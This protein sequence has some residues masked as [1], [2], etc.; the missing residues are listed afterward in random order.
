MTDTKEAFEAAAH[1]DV[2]ARYNNY[3]VE[4]RPEWGAD[5]VSTS[6]IPVTPIL[7]DEP[8]SLSVGGHAAPGGPPPHAEDHDD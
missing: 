5:K 3:V 8:I 1:P 4:G 7:F 6:A 2:D